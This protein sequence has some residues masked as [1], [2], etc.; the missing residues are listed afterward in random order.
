MATMVIIKT[1]MRGGKKNTE[2]LLQN[3]SEKSESFYGNFKKALYL[4]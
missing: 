3:V 1:S 2:S 4:H